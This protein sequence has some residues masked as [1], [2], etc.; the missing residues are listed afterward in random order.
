MN[1]NELV[2]KYKLTKEDFWQHKQSGSWIIKHD[3]SEKIAHLENIELVNMETLNSDNT[4]VRFL[5][6]MKKGDKTITSVGEADKSNCQS[7]YLGCMA[8]KRGIDRCVLKLINAYQYG[9]YSDAEADDFK[10]DSSSSLSGSPSD[11]HSSQVSKSKPHRTKGNE[12]ESGLGVPFNKESL[13][14]C[15]Y[16]KGKSYEDT[17]SGLPSKI[18]DDIKYWRGN[19]KSDIQKTHLNNL[20]EYRK[21]SLVEVSDGV[22]E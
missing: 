2:K 16:A 6:T 10:N 20:L 13:M 22:L 12:I 21:R 18:D 7:K 1:I 3:C 5:I 4:M 9:V 11:E 14:E 8:E 17:Y 15:G 19:A